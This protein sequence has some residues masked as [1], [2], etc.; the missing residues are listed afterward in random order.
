[1]RMKEIFTAKSIEEAKHLAVEK[2]GVSEDQIV[3]R[4]L[5]EPKKG[6]FGKVKREAQ[7]EA[8]YE[9][10]EE[11]APAETTEAKAPEQPEA[12]QPQ[13]E[14]GLIENDGQDDEQDDADVGS[15]I[16]LHQKRLAEEAK[17]LSLI[18]I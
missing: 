6:I 16:D 15:Q 9:A 1:M 3:F 4:I 14:A 13:A 11:A 17:I 5:E 10:A 2:F 18:H 12:P 8:V 7:V